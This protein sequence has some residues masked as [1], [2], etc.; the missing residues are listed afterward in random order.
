MRAPDTNERVADELA[1]LELK[2]RL[3]DDL[4]QTF[5]AAQAGE[6]EADPDAALRDR[7]WR[8]FWLLCAVGGIA[9]CVAILLTIGGRHG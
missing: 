3:G 5:R 8:A 4:Q 1:H 9:L 2:D 7:G 6:V